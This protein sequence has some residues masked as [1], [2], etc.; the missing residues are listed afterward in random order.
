MY[1]GHVFPTLRER[2]SAFAATS[3][4][5]HVVVFALYT[6]A[7]LMSIPGPVVSYSTES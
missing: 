7:L 3:S 2:L 1:A 4:F 6:S 5:Q